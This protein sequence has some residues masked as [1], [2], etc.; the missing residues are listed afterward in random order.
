MRSREGTVYPRGEWTGWYVGEELLH[1]MRRGVRVRVLQGYEFIESCDPF[2]TYVRGMFRRKQRA[3]GG[4]RTMFKLLLNALYGKFGQQG[5]TVRA[6]PVARFQ[7]LSVAPL[8]WRE[9]NGIII[10]TQDGVP[11]VWSNMVWPAFVTARARMRLADEIE[12]VEAAGGRPLYCDTDSV[13]FEGPGPRYIEKARRIGQMERRGVY[14]QM[15]IVGKKE[16]ALDA[17][18]G[19]WEFHAKG[20]PW[21]EREAYLKTG[22]ATF[23]RPVKMRESGRIGVP[24]GV[25][26]EVTKERKTKFRA[27]GRGAAHVPIAGALGIQWPEGRN[28]GK[29]KGQDRAE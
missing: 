22:R 2:R 3:R 12:R 17:G 5:L 13:I 8:D 16:Y 4:A 7:A 9:W 11:P 6:M 15:L 26:R 25:W 21:S 29:G 23:R 28:H 24:A 27:D 20:I 14:R 10:F 1:A 18:R 19:R